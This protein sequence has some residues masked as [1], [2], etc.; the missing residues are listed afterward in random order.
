MTS[1]HSPP[2]LYKLPQKKVDFCLFGTLVRVF[3]LFLQTICLMFF[4]HDV[5]KVM[6]NNL[7]RTIIYF[8]KALIKFYIR[9]CLS[10]F[11]CH[12]EKIPDA[13]I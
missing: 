11:P 2:Q 8:I 10:N 9:W 7:N 5:Y 4:I 13:M 1:F 6:S 3:V 12:W